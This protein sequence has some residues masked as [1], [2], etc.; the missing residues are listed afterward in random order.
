MFATVTRAASD[1][2]ANFVVINE[3]GWAWVALIGF[4]ALLLL[5][6]ILVL[7][8]KPKVLPLKRAAVE[9]LCWTAIGLGFTLVVWGA[10]GAKAAGEYISGYLIEQSLSI[11]N[12][13][14]WALIFTSFAVPLKYQHRVL[15]WGI[16]GALVMRAIFIF[17]GV[18]LIERFEWILFVFGGFLV[19]TAIRLVVKGDHDEEFDPNK[20][21]VLRAVRRVVPSTPNY[22]GQK[23]FIREDARRLATPL[24]AVLVLVESTDVVFAVDSVP[25]VL[26]VAHDQ[27]IVF[28]SNAFAILGLRALY[29]LL[30]DMRARFSY[31]QQGLAVILAFVGVKM[32]LSHWVHIETWI[33]LLV[34]VLVLAMSVLMSLQKSRREDTIEEATHIG[35]DEPSEREVP[36][37]P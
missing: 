37:R 24:F 6:D 5:F 29:F 1:A 8:R 31:L 36:D 21:R 7:H 17:A 14:V 35:G 23:L 20:S 27:F 22:H 19:L 4:I 18:A 16:F 11:D 12:V 26:A 2:N 33:S 10:W 13:F 9:W 34:I 25:A 3:P 28:S 32:I 30:A 15:F